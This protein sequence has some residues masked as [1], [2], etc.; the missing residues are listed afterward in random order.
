MR[1]GVDDGVG[2]V[3]REPFG[4]AEFQVSGDRG[5]T[6]DVAADVEVGD[7]YQQIRAG[8]VVY[9]GDSAGLEFEF[10]DADGVFDKHDLLRA[11]V[12]DFEG[13]VLILLDGL[14][15]IPGRRGVAEGFVLEDFDGD[16]AEGLVAEA[17]DNM[18]E[19]GEG[20]A[21]IAVLKFDGD[22]RLVFDSVD[23]L[24]GAQVDGDI[25]MTMP[26]HESVGVSGDVDVEDA[27]GFVFKREMVM[28]FG[29]DFDFG[30]GS[31]KGE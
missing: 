15:S 1:S 31:L 30:G 27:D 17:P 6:R 23:D 24:G 2:V 20:E 18:G 22:W 11:T 14:F 5:L 10:G 16:V 8:L 4:V 28:R 13:A 12:E 7:G 3:G 21:G 26:V 9:G 29:G 25:I 19:G